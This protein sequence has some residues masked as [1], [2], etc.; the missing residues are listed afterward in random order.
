MEFSWRTILILVGLLIVAGILIDGFRRMR[1]ARSEALGLDVVPDQARDDEYNPELPG[2]GF[3]VI[4][5]SDDSN[6]ANVASSV[7][8]SATNKERKT[9]TRADEILTD[10]A[11]NNSQDSS[12]PHALDPSINEADLSIGAFSASRSDTGISPDSGSLNINSAGIDNAPIGSAGQSRDDNA[13]IPSLAA[14]LKT[15][16]LTTEAESKSTEV[17]KSDRDRLATKETPAGLDTSSAGDS[18]EKSKDS[19]NDPE[20]T[21]E[22]GSIDGVAEVNA[23]LASIQEEK[24]AE[25]D[26]STGS[27]LDDAELNM[28]EAVDGERSAENQQTAGPT[29]LNARTAAIADQDNA[30]PDTVRAPS[31][32][33]RLMGNAGVQI[34]SN[35]EFEPVAEA[36]VKAPAEVLAEAASNTS[37]ELAE[38]QLATQQV[39]D[40]LSTAAPEIS[41]ADAAELVAAADSSV[42]E[43][44]PKIDQ[45]AEV[46][47]SPAV[48]NDEAMID[49][50]LDD[51]VDGFPATDQP[52]PINYPADD[53]E[54]LANRPEPELVLVINTIASDPEGF[55]GEAL[56]FLLTSCDLRFGEKNIFHRFEQTDGRGCIQFSVAQSHEPGVFNPE[57]MSNQ[58]FTGL[59]FF[60]SL[61]GASKPLEAY[62][63]MYELAMAISRNLKAD[64]LDGSF[65]AMTSQTREH[66]R[67]LILDFE[68]KRQL[69]AK[70]AQR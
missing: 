58:R 37:A 31:M 34:E 70:K 27:S 20:H 29:I 33:E 52:L 32:F 4:R 14:V 16:T 24:V 51:E 3:R 35:S 66:D 23:L 12:T 6:S 30:S 10:G 44:A 45:V 43:L 13:D 54:K 25:V 59:T 47:L 56:L 2:S 40:S 48:E 57:A 26:I 60:L 9:P 65:S 1:Q 69:S 15:N 22:L 64:V 38:A 8:T 63:A 61:P 67:Q 46:A 53:A 5:D 55:D 50:H 28:A 7:Q 21:L 11:N 68:R 39:L 18:T 17:E 42:T 49:P 19:S 36:P 41:V 62:E